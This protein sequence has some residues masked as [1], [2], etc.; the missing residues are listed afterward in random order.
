MGIWNNQ[1][2]TEARLAGTNASRV[3]RIRVT[4][5]AFRSLYPLDGR[6]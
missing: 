6:E 3:G 1:T 2:R 5:T 4:Q